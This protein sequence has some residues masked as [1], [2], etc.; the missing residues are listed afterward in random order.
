MD[1]NTTGPVG[2]NNKKILVVEDEIALLKVLVEKFTREGFTTFEAQDGVEGLNVALKERP[3]IILLDLV[4]PKM[5]G[6][7]VLKKLRETD[8]WGKKVPI[9]ILTNL[10]GNDRLMHQI[11][12]N[13]ATDYIVKSNWKMEDMVKKVKGFLG[14]SG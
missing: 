12:Q 3:D 9:I 14:I 13:E 2:P 11:S 4:M 8:E 7:D 6:L 1:T 5:T 10:T